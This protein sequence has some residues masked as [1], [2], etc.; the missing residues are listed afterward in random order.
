M[1]QA[2]L[3]S[4]LLLGG[5]SEAG[6]VRSALAFVD[7]HADELA[8]AL[9]RGV[10][11]LGRRGVPISPAQAEALTLSQL[12]AE[13]VSPSFSV[14]LA[15]DPGGSRGALFFDAAA[16]AFLLDGALGGDGSQ[17]PVLEGAMLSPAQNALLARV[18]EAV[19]ATASA[20]LAGLAGF[21]LL[22]LPNT[23]GATPADS[24]AIALRLGLGEGAAFGTVVLALGRDALLAS[25]ATA[26]VA[27]REAIEPRVAATLDEV[28][29]E[30]V[31]EL[32]RVR[33]RLDKLSALKVGDV[34]DLDVPV[35]GVVKVR[36]GNCFLLDGHPTTS[37]SQVAIRV[38]R[39]HGA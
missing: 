31:A 30:V 15:T 37:G 1:N 2:A 38:A 6:G 20:Q 8:G 3:A 17:P 35:G 25:S 28:E 34:I 12:S 32:G 14:L 9:R 33:M 16:C 18:A 11:F 10:P 27:R 19:V 5:A 22:R 13:L 29:L 7:R 23:P 24:P 21:R 4:P 36:A 26:Q 39:R